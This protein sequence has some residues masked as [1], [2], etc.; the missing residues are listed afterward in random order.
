MPDIKSYGSD[1]DVWDDEDDEN[2][3]SHPE[4]EKVDIKT[5]PKKDKSPDLEELCNDLELDI[6][7]I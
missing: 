4:K 5:K 3:S 2:S 6:D 7:D 1:V